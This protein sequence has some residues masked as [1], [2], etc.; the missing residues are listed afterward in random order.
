M[1]SAIEG[2]IRQELAQARSVSSRGDA[3]GLGGAVALLDE[4]VG[5][6]GLA[7]EGG[8]LEE[9]G[10]VLG[11]EDDRHGAWDGLAGGPA[12]VGGLA[13][14]VDR[15]RDRLAGGQVLADEDVVAQLTGEGAV[16]G[17]GTGP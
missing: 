10:L 14:G 7:Q 5:D 2:K 6:A 17:G 9:V 3:Q 11:G 13:G 4:V 8:D 16:R 15:L 12:E 1:S